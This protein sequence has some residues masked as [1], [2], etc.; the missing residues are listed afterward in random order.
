MVTLADGEVD[1]DRATPVV[2][3]S[4]VSA[5]QAAT[6]INAR[7]TPSARVRNICLL[8]LRVEPVTLTA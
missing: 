1:D 5:V 4:A 6:T 8:W 7:T 3:R 2:P